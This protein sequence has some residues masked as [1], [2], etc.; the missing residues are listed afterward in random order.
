MYVS[1]VS[2]PNVINF[3]VNHHQVEGRLHKVFGLIGLEL[4]VMDDGNIVASMDRLVKGK[5]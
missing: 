2:R 5:T 4:V 1:Y 3:H